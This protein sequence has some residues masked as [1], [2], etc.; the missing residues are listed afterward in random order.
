MGIYNGTQ[1]HTQT[2]T[3]THK[4]NKR[5][6]T[7]GTDSITAGA[8]ANGAQGATG[9]RAGACQRQPADRFSVV[10][11]R[12]STPQSTPFLMGGQTRRSHLPR[13]Q[14]RGRSKDN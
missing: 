13:S 6:G 5:V 8:S 14:R 1:T 9:E 10:A 7:V 2:H 12:A 3:H 11:L 4:G